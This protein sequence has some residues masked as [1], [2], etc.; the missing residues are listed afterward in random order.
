MQP[1]LGK[2]GDQHDQDYL[3]HQRQPLDKS[4]GGFYLLFNLLS[5]ALPGQA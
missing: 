2:V 1:V 5:H 4:V 3:D